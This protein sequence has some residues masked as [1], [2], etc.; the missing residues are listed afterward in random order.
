M[1]V[2]RKRCILRETVDGLT[3]IALAMSFFFVPFWSKINIVYLCS[4]NATWKYEGDE[5]NRGA[6]VDMTIERA[7]RMI[8]LCEMK[9]YQDKFR[10]TE[11]YVARLRE[12]RDT[13]ISTKKVKKT[14]LHT[15]VTTFG[16]ANPSYC[17]LV[18]SEVTMD[19]LFLPL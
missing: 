17:S 4:E 8:H 7:D 14:V 9:F 13:F 15:F 1:T 6:Q 11:D 10:L 5:N 12:R 19:D 3:Y 16:L 18:H 2:V